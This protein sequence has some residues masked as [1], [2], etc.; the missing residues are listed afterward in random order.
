M[1]LVPLSAVI[2][3]NVGY[4]CAFIYDFHL[5]VIQTVTTLGRYGLEFGDGYILGMALQDS[6]FQLYS[7]IFLKTF[8]FE[9]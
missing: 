3:K 6:V 1:I 7:L 2:V 5:I 8:S 9:L 4:H